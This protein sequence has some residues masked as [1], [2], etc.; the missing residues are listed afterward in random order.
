M[1]R[2]I[3]FLR[4][5]VI[6]IHGFGYF[7][8]RL[9]GLIAFRPMVRQ[10]IMVVGRGKTVHLMLRLKREEEEEAEIPISPSREIPN[11]QKT[12]Y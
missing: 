11:N 3:S 12:S 9:V 6:F 4:K 2:I 7:R 1:L 5:K 8:S 10:H